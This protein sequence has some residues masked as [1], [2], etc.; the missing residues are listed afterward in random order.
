M[1]EGNGVP[2]MLGTLPG[3]SCVAFRE[4]E[5]QIARYLAC[6]WSYKRVG[7]AL[8]L[9]PNS[10]AVYVHAMAGEIP[11]EGAPRI[12]VAVWY[13]MNAADIEPEPLGG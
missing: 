3:S 5:L 6:G 9:A 11:G 7:G 2:Q 1:S 4:R 8:D 12:K 10:V 13:A